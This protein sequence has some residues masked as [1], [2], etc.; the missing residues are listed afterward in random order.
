[1][2]DGVNDKN[3]SKVRK[4]DR[5]GKQREKTFENKTNIVMEITTPFEEF[6]VRLSN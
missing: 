6:L 2:H 5:C 3:I 4:L 1:M